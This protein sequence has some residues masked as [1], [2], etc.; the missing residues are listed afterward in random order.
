MLTIIGI[1]IGV[2][3]FILFLI[4]LVWRMTFGG[5][6]RGAISSF[7]HTLHNEDLEVDPE[8]PIYPNQEPRISDIMREEAEIYK[9]GIASNSRVQGQVQQA[10]IPPTHNPAQYEPPYTENPATIVDNQQLANVQPNNNIVSPPQPL[11]EDKSFKENDPI[12]DEQYIDPETPSADTL[13]ASVPES[14]SSPY[15]VRSAS[16]S[17]GRRLRDK[18]YRRNSS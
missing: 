7:F 4:V 6:L 12:I 13:D 9:G 15:G 1:A 8:A 17:P 11:V 3:V 16:H 2:V 14:D 5:M 10:N 18:R